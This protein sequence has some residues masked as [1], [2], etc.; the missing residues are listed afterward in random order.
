MKNKDSEYVNSIISGLNEAVEF[1]KG[2]LNTIKR[3]TVTIAPIP[4]YDAQRIKKIRAS[5]N[6][7]QRIFAK[8]LGVSVKTVEAW[9]SGRNKPQGSAARFLQLIEIDKDILKE[10]QVLSVQ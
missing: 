10:H 2:N 6:L 4:N 9:E 7:T 1:S 8:A 5:L 3:R